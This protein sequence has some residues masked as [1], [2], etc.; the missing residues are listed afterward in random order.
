MTEPAPL[1]TVARALQA[2]HSADELPARLARQ[3]EP[4]LLQ[5][6]Y[7]WPTCLEAG[8]ARL[9]IPWATFAGGFFKQL[10]LLY[11]TLYLADR[12]RLVTN[13]G[14]RDPVGCV[15]AVSRFLCERG[16]ADLPV[17]AV[18]GA[19]ALGRLEEW[20]AEGIRLAHRHTGESFDRLQRPIH[21]AQV[22]LGA[23]PLATA[24]ADGA[25]VVVAGSYCTS[26]PFMAMG[27]DH[28]GWPWDQYD[29]LAGTAM[30]AKVAGLGWVEIDTDG[31]CRL[32]PTDGLSE[33]SEEGLHQ[34]V[35]DGL[36][37]P[38]TKIC[39][40][41]PG[42]TDVACNLDRLHIEQAP[43]G[44][45]IF[46]GIKGK[47]PA[48]EWPVTLWYES[49]YAATAVVE[50]TDHKVAGTLHVPSA[51]IDALRKPFANTAAD[52]SSLQ[53]ERLVPFGAAPDGED[54]KREERVMLRLTCQSGQRGLCEQFV[55]TALQQLG[56]WKTHGICLQDPWPAVRL[57]LA[58]WYTSV[59]RD[60]VAVAVDT[61]PAREW[62]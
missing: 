41:E 6:D 52:E 53:V 4:D 43:N 49:H 20:A 29:A 28:F 47:P 60:M 26:A 17:A 25:R 19:D 31:R 33:L 55:Q 51:I 44:Q 39:E 50:L 3:A 57:Q 54:A 9:S 23:G 38:C 30:A 48:A 2:Y 11:G 1:L 32:T 61:R 42:D 12:F 24:L 36:D 62:L 45:W 46:S 22:H 13:A 15:E 34:L 14:G 10:E 40:Q 35:S 7:F 59:P 37:A 58:P 18:R 27:I 21:G 5:L 16:G 8:D 56:Y